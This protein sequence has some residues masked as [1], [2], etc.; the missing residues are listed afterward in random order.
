MPNQLERLEPGPFFVLE[1]ANRAKEKKFGW[2][3]SIP[4]WRGPW[5]YGKPSPVSKTE[6]SEGSPGGPRL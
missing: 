6:S 4:L 1:I 2:A 3:E 5:Q